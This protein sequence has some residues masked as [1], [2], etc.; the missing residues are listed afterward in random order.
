MA[1][2][3][4]DPTRGSQTPRYESPGSTYAVGAAA[5]VA[6]IALGLLFWTNDTEPETKVQRDT[7]PTQNVVPPANKPTT[8]PG[9][10]PP[11]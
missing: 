6:I 5:V 10:P 7:F 11:Q 9:T 4:N 3:E 1:I 2:N 8:T